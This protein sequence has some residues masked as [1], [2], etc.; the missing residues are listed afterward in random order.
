MIAVI[1]EEFED[2]SKKYA[3][4]YVRATRN[5]SEASFNK[6]VSEKVER[7]RQ[8]TIPRRHPVYESG[9]GREIPPEE[10][11][12]FYVYGSLEYYVVHKKFQA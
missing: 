9:T 12:P 6:R 2:S 4:G 5:E 8:E 1:T 3:I 10:Q 11:K 7:M